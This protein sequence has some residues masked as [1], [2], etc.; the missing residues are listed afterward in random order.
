MGNTNS[1]ERQNYGN[2]YFLRVNFFKYFRK[3]GF[4][5]LKQKFKTK[6]V[7]KYKKF[8]VQRKFNLYTNCK[9]YQYKG[10]QYII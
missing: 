7:K 1:V 4:N 9:I 8:D 6:T 2:D 5:K 10:S 3:K